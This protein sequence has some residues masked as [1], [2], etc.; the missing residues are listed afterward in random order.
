MFPVLR[1]FEGQTDIKISESDL[2]YLNYYN[3]S[4]T[5]PNYTK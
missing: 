5:E 3:F 1:G 4:N 2:L